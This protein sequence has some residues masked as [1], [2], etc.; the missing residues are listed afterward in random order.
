MKI[1]L[2]SSTSKIWSTL[3]SCQHKWTVFPSSSQGSTSFPQRPRLHTSRLLLLFFFPLLIFVHIFHC[4]FIF[5]FS[6][7][8]FFIVF[9][10][11][12]FSIPCSQV[13]SLHLQSQK[14]I[15]VFPLAKL[16]MVLS[17]LYLS[18]VVR[19]PAFCICENKGADQLRGDREADQRLCFR[20]SFAVTAKLISAF[21][22]ATRI[23]QSPYFL[24]PKFQASSHLLWVYSPVCVGPGLKPRRPVFSE[25]G[26]FQ[27]VHTHLYQGLSCWLGLVRL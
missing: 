7:Q 3:H 8:T 23:V 4:L 22:F 27:Y 14:M 18:R 19:K 16:S 2:L 25:R 11:I 6:L 12:K 17:Q 26:S 20:N 1:I 9:F 10:I 13:L 21:V 24:N 15:I 5:F